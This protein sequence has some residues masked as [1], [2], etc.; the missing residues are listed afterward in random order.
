MFD[1]LVVPLYTFGYEEI[2]TIQLYI[3]M[4]KKINR[5]HS[6]SGN[7]EILIIIRVFIN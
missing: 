2:S 3:K 7:F 1:F 4:W 6:G 5:K